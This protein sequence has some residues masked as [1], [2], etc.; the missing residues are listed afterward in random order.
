MAHNKKLTDI[1]T[2]LTG[3]AASRNWH[4]NLKRHRLFE[5][6]ERA[7]GKEIAAQAQPKVIRGTVLWVEVTDS[8][9]M[10]QLHL[11]KEHL[12]QVLNDRIGADGISDIRFSL[13]ACLKPVASWKEQD[14]REASPVMV[15]PDPEKLARFEKMIS[16]I[17]D[18]A[19]RNSFRKLWLVQQGRK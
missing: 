3:L 14:G 8:V 13:T 1:G 4:V 11:L 17:T 9:W 16:V 7:V 6:W 15:A 19:A 2:L 18:D 12:R 5:F 10:Q